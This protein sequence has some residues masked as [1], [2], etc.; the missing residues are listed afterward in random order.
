[1]TLCILAKQCGATI[2]ISHVETRNGIVIFMTFAVAVKK[3]YPTL[4]PGRAN[5]FPPRINESSVIYSGTAE[6]KLIVCLAPAEKGFNYA[7]TVTEIR[8]S[9]E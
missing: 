4:Y 8:N 7:D 6:T 3:R 1:M 5:D 2:E 9:F